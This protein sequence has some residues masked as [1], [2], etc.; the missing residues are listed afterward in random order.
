MAQH[1][2]GV[3]ERTAEVLDDSADLAEEHALRH[4]QAGRSGAAWAE[5]ATAERAL[6]A[7]QQAREAADRAREAAKR[8]RRS[9]AEDSI[10]APRTN[11]EHANY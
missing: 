3:Y 2:A 6:Q 11:Q 9:L 5:L 7:A 4:E 10:P 8:I 1:A